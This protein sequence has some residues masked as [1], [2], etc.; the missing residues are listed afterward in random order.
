MDILTKVRNWLI[1]QEEFE[2]AGARK[3]LAE[4][5]ERI[6]A[7]SSDLA[8]LNEFDVRQ[9]VVNGGDRADIT[10]VTAEI[11]AVNETLDVLSDERDL[12]IEDINTIHARH[13]RRQSYVF[14]LIGSQR[15]R[16]QNAIVDLVLHGRVA[17]DK[18]KHH[19]NH[20]KGEIA[21]MPD[22][23]KSELIAAL[24]EIKLPTS[25]TELL[26]SHDER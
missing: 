12:L 2:T 23:I 4:I 11:I 15:D 13:S 19:W 16:R 14:D 25:Y 20:F 7:E 21:Q 6:A 18:H 5:E 8:S 3:R 1:E 22:E 17:A 9:H 10:A 26:E 24:D